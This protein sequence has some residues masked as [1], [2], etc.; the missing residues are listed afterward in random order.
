MQRYERIRKLH[1]LLSTARY[2]VSRQRLMTELE[3]SEAT[4]Y[5][6]IADLRDG[7]G[8]PLCTDRDSGAYFYDRSERF[9]LPGLW[10][11]AS[12]LHALLVAD[13]L[14]AAVEPGLMNAK[15]L[16]L[17][18]RIQS[19]LSDESK[20]SIE[21]L[22]RI[23]VLG[24]GQRRSNSDH[25]RM[26]AQA[27]LERRRLLLG[28]RSRTSDAYAERVVSPQRLTLYRD[29]WYLDA[30]CH[31]RRG[32]RIFAVDRIERLRLRSEVAKDVPE[33]TLDEQLAGAFG[34]FA[35]VPDKR[36]VLAFSEHRARWVAEEVWHPEQI[37]RW[38]SDGR[39]ELI[40]PYRHE[41]ELVMDLLKYGPE[42]EVVGP[43]SLRDCV[44]KRLR[45]ACLLYEA[46]G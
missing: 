1:R 37:G 38:R 2:P 43:A 4:V 19:A 10:F 41:Q 16:A 23:R 14:L 27:V 25:L 3:C 13:K 7:L 12:E 17:R 45:A 24:I 29:N 8:A 20:R 31:M 6:V 21:E 35:G 36:A 46:S 30:W 34:I 22:G 39:Y 9:E 32:L 33:S 28:Y 15:V 40:V 18:D 5:R 26:A 44:A 42:V 11:T